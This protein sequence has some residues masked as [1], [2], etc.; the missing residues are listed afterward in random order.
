MKYGSIKDTDERSQ[1][2]GEW[3]SNLGEYPY[4]DTYCNLN[5]ANYDFYCGG[6]AYNSIY[7]VP[8]DDF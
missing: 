8:T 7:E 2:D 5:C 4:T 6:I 3:D 1:F